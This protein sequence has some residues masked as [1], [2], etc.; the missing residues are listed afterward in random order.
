MTL[1][2]LAINEVGHRWIARRNPRPPDSPS[3]AQEEFLA[4]DRCP[5]CLH[6]LMHVASDP[7]D[8]CTVCPECGGAWRLPAR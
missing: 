1:I 4:L 6:D 3:T 5:T 7:A 8:G 2:L